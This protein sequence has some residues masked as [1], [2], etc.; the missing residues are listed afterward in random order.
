MELEDT[1]MD[2]Y[3][4]ILRKRQRYYSTVYGPRINIQDSQFYSW[5]LNDW[6]RLMGINLINEN[7]NAH[8]IH[9]NVFK[10]HIGYRAFLRSCPGFDPDSIRGN[11]LNRYLLAASPIETQSSPVLMF[12]SMTLIPLD[13]LMW[14]PSVLVLSPG[15]EMV[16]RMK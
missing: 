3:L 16:E 1:H 7:R 13:P 9:Y 11:S 10:M 4:H 5:L 14:I 2:A 8:I 15:A 12:E 6:E